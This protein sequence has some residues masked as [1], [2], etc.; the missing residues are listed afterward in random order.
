M[1]LFFSVQR[2]KLLN[3]CYSSFSISLKV[4]LTM[5]YPSFLRIQHC[6]AAFKEIKFLQCF[7]LQV[8]ILKFCDMCLHLI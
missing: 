1:G 2:T 3:N 5:S 4:V 7:L 6:D 8:S